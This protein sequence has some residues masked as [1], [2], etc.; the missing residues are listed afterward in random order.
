MHRFPHWDLATF[1]DVNFNYSSKVE[2]RALG[3][4]ETTP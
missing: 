3:S 4:G 2:W 1:C